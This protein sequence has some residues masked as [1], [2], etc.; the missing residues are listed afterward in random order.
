[1][2]AFVSG[3]AA[4]TSPGKDIENIRVVFTFYREPDFFLSPEQLDGS[5]VDTV[6]SEII[7]LQLGELP[8]HNLTDPILMIFKPRKVSPDYIEVPVVKREWPKKSYQQLKQKCKC[9][10]AHLML[11]CS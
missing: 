6:N 7:A 4:D 10:C 2:S 1:M 3:Q 9:K 5:E 11:S 8:I